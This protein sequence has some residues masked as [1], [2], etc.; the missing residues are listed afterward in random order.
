MQADGKPNLAFEWVIAT[1]ED[2]T[3]KI[4]QSS[5]YQQNSMGTVDLECAAGELM[6]S[7]SD[8]IGHGR[9]EVTMI[10]QVPVLSWSPEIKR[11]LQMLNHQHSYYLLIIGQDATSRFIPSSFRNQQW[12]GEHRIEYQDFCNAGAIWE[13]TLD[14]EDPGLRMYA[15]QY[16]YSLTGHGNEK[17]G[18]HFAEL[19]DR[20]DILY[21]GAPSRGHPYQHARSFPNGV[22]TFDFHAV[23]AIDQTSSPK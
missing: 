22:R 1:P 12:V 7:S 2:S 14:M 5:P 10:I 6:A 20:E 23:I 15:K 8:T 3:A 11:T 9:K 17:A 4:V 21:V 18:Q 19:C 16:G 13:G